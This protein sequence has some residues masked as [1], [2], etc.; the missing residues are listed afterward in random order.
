MFI[1]MNRFKIKLGCEAEF[2]QIWKN[3]ETFLQQVP[4]FKQFE[5]LKGSETVDH[6]LY[7]SHSSWES[8]QAFEDWTHSA[9]FKKAHAQA[10]ARKE[11]YLGPPQLELF[12][13]VLSG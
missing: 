6:C 7:A 5:L 3:R 9:A 13:S 11:I 8:K 1:A 4:G 2:E 10:G 12:E